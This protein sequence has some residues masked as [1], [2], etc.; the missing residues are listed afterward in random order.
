MQDS[1]KE[2]GLLVKNMEIDNQIHFYMKI[3]NEVVFH[4]H[5]HAYHVVHNKKDFQVRLYNDLPPIAPCLS[6]V[7]NGVCYVATRC[8]IK[9]KKKKK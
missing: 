1:E 4:D 9:K 2:F 7:K 5:Y 6:I 3:Y 8:F